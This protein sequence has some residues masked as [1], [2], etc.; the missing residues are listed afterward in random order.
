MFDATLDEVDTHEFVVCE[1]RMLPMRDGVRLATDV[2]R[3][4]HGRDQPDESN[5]KRPVVLHRTP[6]CKVCHM[7]RRGRSAWGASSRQCLGDQESHQ[8]SN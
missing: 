5:G 7:G 2:Y 3:P 1:H 4:S 8:D 6:Y